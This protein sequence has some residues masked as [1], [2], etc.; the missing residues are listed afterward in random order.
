MSSRPSS[1]ILTNPSAF[2]G[3]AVVYTLNQL[4]NFP[5]P[6]WLVEN[7]V[8]AQALTGLCGAPGIGK[9]M[10]ALDWAL[11]VATGTPWFDKKVQ[12]GFALYIA[13]EGHSGLG[14]RAK[15]WL[16]H[17]GIAP[18]R[19]QFGLVKG[20]LTI[21]GQA[22]VANPEDIADYDTLF[23]RIDSEMQQSP[24]LV[25]IDTLAR[26]LEGDENQNFDMGSFL[27]GA[28]RLVEEYD[29]TV[30][31]IHHKN[32]IG[33]RERGHTSFRGTLGSLHFVEK[34]PKH[35]DLLM[36][37]NDKQRDA[38]EHDRIGMKLEGVGM[39][40]VLIPAELPLHTERGKG[41]IP[42][43]MTKA[44][45]LTMLAAAENGYTFS[46]W[47]LASQVPRRTFARRVNQLMGDG[48][49]MKDEGRYYVVPALEDIVELERKDDE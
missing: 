48:E 43:V 14:I 44:S 42:Q 26:C 7:L 49:I 31:I 23:K 9:S 41:T 22:D 32:A 17:H 36:L 28:E 16:D 11:S 19:A 10:L 13:A 21:K 8:P 4:L 25:V 30:V 34:V 46:E 27:N 6:E 20:R 24:T 33:N 45:M 3:K 15:A 47:R 39:S 29:S 35:P 38:K 37:V 40:A 1:F 2:D 12:Q 5:P 18:S